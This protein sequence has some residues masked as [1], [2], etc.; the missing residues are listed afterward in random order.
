MSGLQFILYNK[1]FKT[2]FTLKVNKTNIQNTQQQRNGTLR[3][4]IRLQ[5]NITIT[6]MVQSNYTQN[7]TIYSS[8][9]IK[10]FNLMISHQ[11]ISIYGTKFTDNVTHINRQK[12]QLQIL[13]NRMN[14]KTNKKQKR[15]Q[16]Q[17]RMNQHFDTAFLKGLLKNKRNSVAE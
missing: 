15:E 3:H 12:D 5:N 2:K 16:M 11:Q 6:T 14:T 7:S 10:R 9:L 17:N 13:Q 4:A 8:I 1:D